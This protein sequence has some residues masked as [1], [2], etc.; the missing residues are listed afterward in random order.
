MNNDQRLE[1]SRALSL[2]LKAWLRKEGYTPAKRLATELGIDSSTWGRIASGSGITQK[3]EVYAKIFARTGLREADPRSV[4]PIVITL[5]RGGETIRSISMEESEFQEWMDKEGK[6]YFPSEFSSPVGKTPSPTTGTQ[7][8]QVKD[9]S[10]TSEATL[11]HER[12]AQPRTPFPAMGSGMMEEIFEVLFRHMLDPFRVY[13]TGELER[14]ERRLLD[15]LQ[16]VIQDSISRSVQLAVR[17]AISK[18]DSS[19]REATTQVIS[20][21]LMSSQDAI[22]NRFTTHGEEVR[23]L[24][25]EALTRP[26]TAQTRVIKSYQQPHRV[27]DPGEIA[28]QLLVSLQP[29]LN[30]SPRDRDEIVKRFGNDF[31]QLAPIVQALSSNPVDREK[32]LMLTGLIK[33]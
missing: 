7:S 2:A 25:E 23:E 12:V 8:S 32:L 31:G 10:T 13:L 4:P 14:T 33:E 28:Q 22:L 18:L 30:G 9:P 27:P 11:S 5:P 16:Q 24:V 6:K 29:A 20:E 19:V 3:K 21:R 26:D 1:W 15:G 17:D